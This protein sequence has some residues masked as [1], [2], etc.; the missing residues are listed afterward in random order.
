MKKLWIDPNLIAYAVKD[1]NV[2]DA[3]ALCVLIKLR[4]VSSRVKAAGV[5]RLM[6][7]FHVSYGRCVKAVEAGLREGWLVEEGSDIVARR[8]RVDKGCELPLMLPGAERLTLS[9][10]CNI[11]REALTYNHISK[12]DD[13]RDTIQLA[14][15]P[16]PGEMQK[17]KRARRRLAKHG[18]PATESELKKSLRMSYRRCAELLCV[19]LTKAKS[20]IK[21]LRLAG[22]ISR[23]LQFE[24]TAIPIGQFSRR[25]QR[26][27]ARH[28][29]RG[30]LVV[31]NAT[32]CIQLANAYRLTA[33]TKVK[34]QY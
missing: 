12:I 23:T 34:F 16:K 2:L 10:M 21:R 29:N 14:H 4:F 7:L 28:G 31:N 9:Q 1:K 26:E 19:S 22:I 11:L 17:C 15:N 20:I 32:V 5:R 18:M 24:E 27:Y 25:M 30:Y 6:T 33:P 13:L 3:L 8:L